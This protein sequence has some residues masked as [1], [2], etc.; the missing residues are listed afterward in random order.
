MLRYY[1]ENNLLKPA[2]VDPFTNYRLYSIEQIPTLNKIRFLR[3]LS[4]SVQ[5]ISEALDIWEKSDISL[6][7]DNK[8]KEITKAIKQQEDLLTKIAIAKNDIKTKQLDINYNVSLK[9]VPAYQVLS[10]R[11][12]V[13]DYFAEESLWAELFEYI[14]LNKIPIM[15]HSFSIYHDD[16][17]K[18][19]EVDIEIC[20]EVSEVKK[21]SKYLYRTTAE[22]PLMACTMVYGPFSGIAEVYLNFAFWI[23]KHSQYQMAPGCRQIVHRGPWNEKDPLNYL[24]EVQI[25]L[26]NN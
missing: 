19:S 15:Q 7:L 25:P 13:S 2:E 24:T 4:F 6:L 11:K 20:V 16:E 5:E 21:D 17:Y 10:Y 9:A 23:S 12:V 18:E 22:V 8:Q 26:L 3:D 1:D 14:S